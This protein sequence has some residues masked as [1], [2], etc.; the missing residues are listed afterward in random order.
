MSEPLTTIAT[1]AA[2]GSAPEPGSDDARRLC[3]DAAAGLLA[4]TS[5]PHAALTS[6]VADPRLVPLQA[7]RVL[8]RDATTAAPLHAEGV[9]VAFA[10]AACTIAQPSD[11]SGDVRLEGIKCLNNALLTSEV[12]VRA[13]AEAE[14][15][16]LPVRVLG[17][18][19]EE[20]LDTA[21]LVRCCRVLVYLCSSHG[22]SGKRLATEAGGI[23]L[24]VT[25]LEQHE[26]GSPNY[27]D[28]DERHE[29]IE[30]L[31]RLMFVFCFHVEGDVRGML[32]GGDS[33]KDGKDDTE[34]ADTKK[35]AVVA[36]GG[37][38]GQSG[39]ASSS[40]LDAAAPEMSVLERSMERLGM[41]LRDMLLNVPTSPVTEHDSSDLSTDPAMVGARAVADEAAGGGETKEA[42]GGAEAAGAA[43]EGTASIAVP[44]TAADS[45][46]HAAVTA[47]AEVATAAHL[48]GIEIKDPKARVV[49]QEVAKILTLAPDAFFS[50]LGAAGAAPTIMALLYSRTEVSVGLVAAGAPMR[51][52]IQANDDLFPLLVASHKLIE[53]SPSAHEQFKALIF[54]TP[55]DDIPDNSYVTAA[56]KVE[57]HTQPTDS[58][59]GSF[60]YMLLKL[61]TFTETGVK[62][63]ASEFLW[64]LCDSSAEEFTARTGF[65][66]A[67]RFSYGWW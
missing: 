31:L 25:A 33:T 17:V 37:C 58:P 16:E 8:L 9:L 63:A 2:S 67:V 60:R 49:V 41:A 19:R 11:A 62:R 1:V 26:I 65:G 54:P 52:Q 23:E 20:G 57:K 30:Y 53:F 44:A 51:V 61:M 10:E 6:A 7:S 27:W 12:A 38:G 46:A 40:V 59:F 34:S 43:T 42:G 4:A 32:R 47:A 28:V 24:L 13:F 15:G 55:M 64:M 48:R 29:R 66:N 14:G 45:A 56:G 35:D 22:S 3:A 21:L 18:L 50:F 5:A 39:V 36:P